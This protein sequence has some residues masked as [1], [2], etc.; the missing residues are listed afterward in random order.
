M[1]GGYKHHKFAV[2]RN[3]AFN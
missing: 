2:S 3:V 1:K